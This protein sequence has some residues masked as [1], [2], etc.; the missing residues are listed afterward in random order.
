VPCF[1]YDDKTLLHLKQSFAHA[2][3]VGFMGGAEEEKM[4]DKNPRSAR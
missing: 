2:Q 3:R 1:Q 4:R